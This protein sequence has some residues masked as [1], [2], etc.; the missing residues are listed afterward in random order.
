MRRNAAGIAI[1]MLVMLGGAGTLLYAEAGGPQSPDKTAPPVD[2]PL[3]AFVKK[4]VAAAPGEFAALKGEEDTTLGKDNHDMFKGT[5]AADADSKCTLFIRRGKRMELSPD[6]NCQLGPTQ[7]LQNAKPVYEKAAAELRAAFPKW[8]FKE[9]KAGD[10]SKRE[11]AWSL[12]AEQPGFTVELS[13]YDAGLL[14]ELLSGKT[15]GQP[16]VL[17]ELKL[18]DTLPEKEKPKTAA[19]QEMTANLPLC[20]FIEKVRAARQNDYA[21]LRSARPAEASGAILGMLRPDALSMCKVYPPKS[22]GNDKAF[23]LCEMRRA[24]TME[25]IKPEYERLK[26]ELQACYSNLKFDESINDSEGEHADVWFYSGKDAV[27]QLTAQARDDGY[28]LKSEPEKVDAKTKQN[29]VS[30]VLQIR[31]L[32]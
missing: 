3:I 8:K 12:T 24:K 7:T 5:L 32:Q 28:M 31:F 26:T 16:G 17:V 13:L 6:Y 4:A 27:Y 2:T 19:A 9:E 29:P 14:A 15:S 23:Y 30:L 11:E 10:E 25:E 18:S 21:A 20:K 1:A 22:A